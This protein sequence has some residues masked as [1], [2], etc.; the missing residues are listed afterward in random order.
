[1]RY[2]KLIFAFLIVVVI[3]ILVGKPGC[4]AFS[5]V[6]GDLVLSSDFK[7]PNRKVSGCDAA[8]EKKKEEQ[9]VKGLVDGMW[10]RSKSLPQD[11]V[12]LFTELN[13]GGKQISLSDVPYDSKKPEWSTT[14][15]IYKQYNLNE[16]GTKYDFIGSWDPASAYIPEGFTLEV[17]DNAGKLKRTYTGPDVQG[18]FWNN[19]TNDCNPCISPDW[20]RVTRVGDK[21]VKSSDGGGGGGYGVLIKK[22]KERKQCDKYAT[23]NQNMFKPCKK[24]EGKKR[25]KCIGKYMPK[26]MI[27]QIQKRNKKDKKDLKKMD[28][29]TSAIVYAHNDFGGS[30][31][32]TLK[33][34]ETYPALSK[35]SWNNK[36]SSAKVMPGYKLELYDHSKYRGK[37][38]SMT[39]NN[40][41]LPKFN[42]KPSAL[43]VTRK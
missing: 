5:D 32:L 33:G 2:T 40:T 21:E 31:P 34:F 6:N 18:G 4:D 25:Y 39:G 30:K 43:V 17:R 42:D 23:K 38:Y 13:F 20:I 16:K 29:Q 37:M 27:D 36:I 35:V 15:G 26:C 28:K 41:S 3:V 7:K 22:S 9:R 8:C 1:M 14:G 19:K 10:N 11:K 24:I 12:T